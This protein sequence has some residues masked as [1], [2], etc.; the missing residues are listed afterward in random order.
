MTPQ[1]AIKQ[2]ICEIGAEGKNFGLYESGDGN[3]CAPE[4]EVIT[5]AVELRQYAI[6]A[7][8]KQDVTRAIDVMKVNGK[9]GF[10]QLKTG[11]VWL[12]ENRK[13]I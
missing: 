7:T 10:H 13:N 8:G 4:K 5:R 1:Q 12:W 2:A 3:P 9:L 11:Q 6:A